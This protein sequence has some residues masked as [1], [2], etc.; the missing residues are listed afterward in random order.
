MT[1]ATLYTAGALLILGALLFGLVV[2]HVRT[3]R[4]YE[5]GEL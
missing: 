3:V 4:R 2:E 5:R 1:P